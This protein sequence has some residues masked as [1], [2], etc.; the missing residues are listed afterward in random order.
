MAVMKLKSSASIFLNHPSH[1]SATHLGESVSDFHSR[2]FAMVL[3]PNSERL[4]RRR[5][6]TTSLS[7]WFGDTASVQIHQGGIYVRYGVGG[8][9]S[10]ISIIV[11]DHVTENN[12]KSY[13]IK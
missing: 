3:G 11:V 10:S 5:I 4:P 1:Y 12:G 8:F 6:L 13:E 9:L 7:L 2:D